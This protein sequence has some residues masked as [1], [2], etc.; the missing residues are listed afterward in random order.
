VLLFLIQLLPKTF[1][2]LRTIQRDT[3]INM[4]TSLRKIQLSFVLQLNSFPY[5]ISRAQIPSFINTRPLRAV[6]HHSIG[7]KAMKALPVIFRN[8]E[9]KSNKKKRNPTYTNV[10]SATVAQLPYPRAKP[11]CCP[12]MPVI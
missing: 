3:V 7:R 6:L 8:F 11:V 1:L 9:N 5:R 2:I 12:T 4:K 10:R